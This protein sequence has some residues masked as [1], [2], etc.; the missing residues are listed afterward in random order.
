MKYLLLFIFVF[1][2]KI[3][4]AQDYKFGKVSKGE[5]QETSDPTDSEANATVLY[6]SQEIKFE[7]IESKGFVQKNEI[8][9]RIKI[10]NKDGFDQATKVIKLY[11][12]SNELKESLT[13]FKAYTY[14]LEGNKIIDDKLKSD[15]IFEEETNRYWLY[16]KFTMPNIKEGCV[17]EYKYT[18]ESELIRID[19]IEFQ[20]EIPIRK[21]DFKM[22]TPE[23][24]NY[25]KYPNV[26]AAYYPK[27]NETY[28]ETTV[29]LSGE[30]QTKISHNPTRGTRSDFSK[31]EW[32]YRE[33]ITTANLVNIPA[34]DLSS[35]HYPDQVRRNFTT[36]WEKVTK[37][38]YESND[39]GEQL[40]KSG[41]F[42][43]D[44]SSA[45]AGA[46][47]PIEQTYNIFNFVKTKVKWNGLHGYYS[48][49][50]VRQ[51]YKQ[52]VGNVADINLI[53]N[54]MLREA[55]LDANP[56]LVSTKD[57]GIPVFPT[58]SGFNYALLN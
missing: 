39:F 5:L 16:T 48:D 58:R 27:L 11:N 18:I 25:A 57:N 43:D 55:G 54:A 44:L 26:K 12:E 45:I 41:Y 47:N 38:I 32:K 15:G 4:T 22:S 2:L 36:N 51:A 42:S 20:Q 29:F 13:G 28:K 50:G 49:L 10:Y 46:T 30:M 31:N 37:T 53:L 40:K 23:F 35:I 3:A 33:N 56:V 8:H 52:G 14:N 9:E 7:Y 21:L 6:R 17:I 24:Y 19:D 1:A 34:M